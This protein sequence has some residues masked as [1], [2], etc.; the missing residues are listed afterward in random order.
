[1]SAFDAF[2]PTQEPTPTN[3]TP[4][5]TEPS[6]V[7][8][9]IGDYFSGFFGGNKKEVEPTP[10]EPVTPT[11]QPKSAF[12]A[13]KPD[14]TKQSAGMSKTSAF[15]AFKPAKVTK[16]I[17]YFYAKNEDGGTIGKSDELDTSGKP[18]LGYR[19][20]G[21]IATT[22]DKTRVATTF[23]PRVPQKLDSKTFLNDRAVANRAA[24][25]DAMGG[26]YSDQL[27]H[28]VSL[29]LSGSNDK[30]NLQIE[31]TTGKG[32]G[33]ATDP[34]ENSLAKDVANGK[35]SLFD[36]QAQL[37]KA[38]GQ[39]AP[40]GAPA[41]KEGWLQQ[42]EHFLIPE[43]KGATTDEI[44][45]S[46]FN[47]MSKQ[48]SEPTLGDAS[49]ALLKSSIT[50]PAD[51][52]NLGVLKNTITGLPKALWNF[53]GVGQ[54]QDYLNTPEGENAAANLDWDSIRTGVIKGAGEYVAKPLTTIA[55][56][57]TGPKTF[58]LPIVGKIDN[59]QKEAVDAVQNGEN[60]YIT[61]FKAVPEA[62]FD[63]LMVAGV[64]EKVF[65]PRE[66]VI[67]KGVKT[68]DL[69]S[70]SEVPSDKSFRVTTPPK[71]V[72]NPVPHEAIVALQKE[73][74]VNFKDYNPELP[75][76]F[77]QTPQGNGVI[78]GEIV[79]LK[80]SY[81]DMFKK[82][83][84]G[85]IQKVP[86]EGVSVVYE[87]TTT[88]DKVK[89]NIQTAI[90]K[91][92]NTPNKQGG[93][94]ANPLAPNTSSEDNNENSVGKPEPVEKGAI[95]GDGKDLAQ[96]EKNTQDYVDKNTPALIKQY[97][98][99]HGNVFN[100]DNMKDLVPDHAENKTLSEG[101]HKPA[102]KLIG[103]MVDTTIKE[104]AGKFKTVNF[105]GGAP[106][107]G[108]SMNASKFLN[109]DI[110]V[111][112]TLADTNRSI[113]QMGLALKKGYKVHINYIDDDPKQI[114]DNAIARAQ[115]NGN[116]GRT[117]PVETI[118][119][120]LQ[121]SR[122]NVLRAYGRFGQGE[123][124]NRFRVSVLDRRGGTNKLI[125]NGIDFL[126]KSVYSDID[127][128]NM[129]KDAYLKIQ[130]L[131]EQGKITKEQEEGF[132][133]RRGE[134]ASANGQ[135]GGRDG[136][137][138]GEEWGEE[139]KGGSLSTVEKSSKPKQVEN[140]TEVSSELKPKN[141]VEEKIRELT[142]QVSLAEESL[143][144][145]P[146]KELA[147]YANK[148]GE[149]PE[150]LGSGIGH[151][152]FKTKGDDI[153]TE[154]GFEDSETARAAY[155][156]Y[157]IQQKRLQNQKLELSK[158]RFAYKNTENLKREAVAISKFLERS[159]SKEGSA[160]PSNAKENGSKPKESQ[161]ALLKRKQLAQRHLQALIGATYNT[162]SPLER[163]TSEHLLKLTEQA[164]NMS[165]GE[166]ERM[167]E[168]MSSYK[169]I[170]VNYQTSVKNKVGIIDYLRTPDRV[171]KKIGLPHTAT[172]LRHSY[173]GY[174]RELPLHIELITNW[175]KRVSPKANEAIFNFLDG[176][177]IRD[178]YSGK[179]HSNHL[180][181]N[182]YKVAMEIKKYLAE[183]ADRL[184]LP[185]DQKIS[186]Y[187]THIFG[188][189][190][191]EKEFDEDLAKIITDKVTGSVYDP[192]LEKRLGA[193][194]YLQDTWKAL[195]AYVKRAV[196]KANMDPILE[197]LS[198][199]SERL[200]LSQLKYVKRL[201]DRINMRPTEIDSA[202]DNTIKTWL[203]YKFGQ[204][205]VAYLSRLARQTVFRY[206][207]GLNFSSAIKN[208][209]QG[210]NTYAKLGEKYTL[211][212]YTKLLTRG[213]QDELEE[214]GVLG[215][216]MVQD[217]VVSSTKKNLEKFDK[218]LFFAF[219]LAEKINRGS[220]YY[221]AK[222]K[223]MD[224]GKS[225]LEAV[226]IAKQLVRDT[227]FNFGAI[228]T[229]VGM[230][231]DIGK[232]LTQFMSY[233]VKQTELAAEMFSNREW[234]GIFRYILASAA[235]VYT[236]GKVFNIKWTD[237]VPAY[238]FMKFSGPP[239]LALPLAITKASLNMPDNF[240]NS[241]TL[242][243]KI[244]DIANQVPFPAGIQLKKTYKGAQALLNQEP[245]KQV[246]RN[247]YNLFKALILGPE[248]IEVR[249]DTIQ[250]IYDK[251]QQLQ[252]AGKTAEAKTLVNS[253]SEKDYSIYSKI[254]VS[255]KAQASKALRDKVRPIY[256]EV[257]K[258]KTA[259]KTKE[260]EDMI[261]SL[262]DEEYK[263]YNSIKKLLNP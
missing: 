238:S 133:R 28:K 132:T 145:N 59:L 65:S 235:I 49:N 137:F 261:N 38:K 197:R 224:E 93:F 148:N 22:T 39:P 214:M 191:N 117:V 160:I 186:H 60:P 102:A 193:K 233:G 32:K 211:I 7:F 112:G 168:S 209:T 79:Q 46:A 83:F 45:T 253:L 91:F 244:T 85:D 171:L 220:A 230:N 177:T 15:D 225:E 158:I 204:R 73:Q 12:D 136:S 48:P 53:L 125:H 14:Q 138:T 251:S 174:L 256:N 26:T 130:Q 13:F 88:L 114:I 189:G 242:T 241:R 94:I 232:F 210:V 201:T 226:Q 135:G 40:W 196:R 115:R 149:L 92:K 154:L 51:D 180:A 182:E 37:L 161:Q 5:P 78:R 9:K 99:K 36:A 199:E 54:I 250:Q 166:F 25:K 202:I 8:G 35:I 82:T 1:M 47:A 134:G 67:G 111:D 229:P 139:R 61:I 257:Q 147:K 263:A 74:G 2:Q 98:E 234:G 218:A 31:S 185:E 90:E 121:K 76:Y 50:P 122:Q 87:K 27:D 104:N 118:I 97:Q 17:P 205:P 183:W 187:I 124:G 116:T 176:Q 34:L 52:T 57:V 96:I 155:Q 30:S 200:E 239:A 80:P 69:P 188:L 29:E 18:F 55:G 129:K 156:D 42:F 70:S 100:V 120:A 110:T 245:A 89:Q 68:N 58:D 194:G 249:K 178:H 23:D 219:E 101:F 119:N 106:A 71:T 56:V 142:E 123:Y 152:K 252:T 237:F 212:G 24:L 192:F 236:L 81:F 222:A 159:F 243:Q 228:D 20:A 140:S 172:L 260:A 43:A 213:A 190:E 44:K 64:A 113:E 173:E 215:Q 103:K 63:G 175:S 208:L 157:K 184:G 203:G 105:M 86:S 11:T 262:S 248:N 258:L 240:G 223:A 255:D 109:A 163:E 41:N 179:V 151:G 33:T 206:S 72:S 127:T 146:A 227:Q 95:V 16:D 162:T 165:L 143:K 164:Y 21:D 19:N 246:D 75:T 231:S 195:D 128:A 3:L 66:S 169:Q 150:V 144:N 167:N 259:G 207:L 77:K 153:V 131:Y 181:P 4:N 107:V 108:K 170:I 217:R 6:N 10:T 216:D 247:P 198:A 62:I 84:N 141:P 126:R 221:G 254:K